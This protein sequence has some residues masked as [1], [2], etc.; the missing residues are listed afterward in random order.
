MAI[1]ELALKAEDIYLSEDA[2]IGEK[3][4]LLAYA[5]SNIKVLEE[6]IKVNY[7]KAFDF[8]AEWMPI[9]NAEFEPHKTLANKRQKAASAASRPTLLRR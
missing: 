1:H 9:L 5:F 3:R 2:T 6:N 8:L 4:L 7:T